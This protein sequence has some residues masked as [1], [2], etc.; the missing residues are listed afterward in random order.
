LKNTIDVDK[1]TL[2][3]KANLVHNLDAVWIHNFIIN[4]ADNSAF[5]GVLPIHDCFGVTMNNIEILNIN[6]R[7]VLTEFFSQ[8]ENL[9]SLLWQL[10]KANNK[11]NQ[12]IYSKKKVKELIGK[13]EINLDNSQYLIFPG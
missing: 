10:E 3:I 12:K 9:Y 7:K 4:I 6:V 11:K 13:L 2:A 8:R 5:N 1:Q